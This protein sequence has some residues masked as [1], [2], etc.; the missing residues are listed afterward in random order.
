RRKSIA[1]VC[2]SVGLSWRRSMLP[3]LN[4]CSMRSSCAAYGANQSGGEA[5]ALSGMSRRTQ[6]AGSGQQK[7]PPV[8]AGRVPL[9]QVSGGRAVEPVRAA[10]LVNLDRPAESIP[11]KLHVAH[12]GLSAYLEPAY[13][14]PCVDRLP[15]PKPLAD[16]PEALNNS[17][18]CR[19]A[20][21]CAPPC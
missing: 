12:D 5:T 4:N 6:A 14:V 13:H 15:E 17:A 9:N 21:R 8:R 7:A 10:G 18:C 1:S 3:R 16:P 11:Q 20:H 2:E 19:F